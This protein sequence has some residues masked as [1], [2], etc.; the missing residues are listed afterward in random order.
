MS[1]DTL[2]SLPLP[3]SSDPL[4]VRVLA[5]DL[6]GN[7]GAPS[8]VLTISLLSAEPGPV[9]LPD[10][11]ALHPA[12][13]NPFNPVTLIPF[14]VGQ[15]GVLQLTVHDLLGREVARLAA[16]TWQRG[17]YRLVWDG[18]DLKGRLAPSGIY[19]VRLLAGD[20][21]ATTK[22]VLLR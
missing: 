10:R 11:F 18:R 3:S 13:P 15:T 4:Y 7:R 22:L 14:D 6:A 21:A 8:D 12:S 20:Y 2:H 16:G 17:S 5:E 19:F 9:G 1:S